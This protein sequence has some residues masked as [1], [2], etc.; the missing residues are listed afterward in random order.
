MI[1]REREHDIR[2]GVAGA[3]TIARV[4]LPNLAQM[5]G[6]LIAA[7]ADRHE[8]RAL[9][10]AF[11][12]GARI[13]SSVERMLDE[14]EL[15]ALFMCTPP[16][17][18]SDVVELAVR[19]G[20][21]VYVEK[22]VAIDLDAALRTA[23]I[24]E[25][26]GVISSVGFMWR[27]APVV[28]QLKA[29]S[30]PGDRGMLLGRLLNGPNAPGWSNDRRLSG[31]IIVEFAAHLADMLRYLGGEVAYVGGLG[32]EIVEGPAT[33]GV[34]SVVVTLQY[35]SGTIGSLAATWALAGSV[36]DVQVVAPGI[37]LRLDF[38]RERLQGTVRGG[39]IDEA[40][41]T[42]I[43]VRPHGF[44]DGPSWYLAAW[45]F[46]R[47]IQDGIPE[48]IRSPYR[49]GVRTLALTLAADEAVR[50]GRSVP[51]PRV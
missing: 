40:S 23:S 36:W 18:H 51:V 8:A 3:G 20:L 33:R 4:H 29:M 17:E 37:D 42:P 41:R 24:V 48:L 38:V 43:D 7:V 50:T 47:A 1:D 16:L 45:T 10:L 26:S 6:V 2:V 25:E 13:Y 14:E 5:D 31:G 34:D 19:R 15:D 35:A 46:I 12:Y 30:S 44:T 49:D 9:P 39:S 21:H 22:P 28:E 27:Y 11:E 32:T